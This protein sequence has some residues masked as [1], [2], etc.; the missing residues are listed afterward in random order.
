[1]APN[2]NKN[3]RTVDR[4]LTPDFS[5]IAAGKHAL[6]H[7]AFADGRGLQLGAS[8]ALLMIH[9]VCEALV[10]VLIGVGID[11][12]IGPSDLSALLWI[13]GALAGLFLM[14]TYSWRH[15]Y[16]LTNRVYGFGDHSLRQMVIAKVLHP[17]ATGKQFGAGR[18]LN[19]AT[20]DTAITAGLSWTISQMSASLAALI[21]AA[22]ALLLIS[23][24]LGLLV[25]VATVVFLVLM[26]FITAPLERRTHLQQ[27]RAA[28]ATGLATDLVSGLRVLQGLGATRTATER[29]RDTSRASLQAALGTAK[30]EALFSTVTLGLSAMFL[31]AITWAAA[32]M[33]L[34]GEISI[35]QLVTVVGL[36]QFIQEPLSSLAYYPAALAQKRAAAKRIATLLNTEVGSGAHVVVRAD[37]TPTDQVAFSELLVRGEGQRPDVRLLPGS[38]TGLRTDARS[39][40]ELGMLLAGRTGDAGARL[41]I[42]GAPADSLAT[43]R[44]TVF[45]ADHD[46]AIFTGS[47]RE[48]L[49]A[50]RLL[51]SVLKATGLAEL[52]AR[53]PLGLDARVGEQGSA[54]SGGQRQRLL[55]ARALHQRQPVIVLTDPTTALDSV[56][57]ARIA[58]A[59][60][61]LRDA[62]LLVI[63]DSPML[64][65][66]CDTVIDTTSLH[67]AGV[68]P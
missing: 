5:A 35:G 56:S 9:Q 43:L 63:S 6:R 67:T 17:R 33:T 41:L 64:L 3:Q 30:S 29:Y 27:E 14:L 42:N 51:E 59:L 55:L 21:T 44:S 34:A 68:N 11:K 39:A 52:C 66:A 50:P 40:R 61:S 25:L 15:G 49:H 32:S 28:E 1:M 53:L 7:G 46:A 20:S 37:P 38:M 16:R 36:A 65:G 8:T 47:F 13:L 4:D 58:V 62:T 12:A 22:A 57:E 45:V 60:G 10:P 24:Q 54:L 19:I 48:N 31:A 26:H 2:I 18:T 23:W